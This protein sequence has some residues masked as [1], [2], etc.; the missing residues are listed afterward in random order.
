MAAISR[1]LCRRLGRTSHYADTNLPLLKRATLPLG[2]LPHSRGEA[3]KATFKAT[4]LDHSQAQH[5]GLIAQRFDVLQEAV[6]WTVSQLHLWWGNRPK[7]PSA[8]TRRT[9]SWSST[10][11]MRG[12]SRQSLCFPRG[13]WTFAFVQD[14]ESTIILLFQKQSGTN[15]V[16][17]QASKWSD[18]CLSEDRLFE[19]DRWLIAIVLEQSFD[20]W[21]ESWWPQG[22]FIIQFR[23]SHDCSFS[24]H[25]LFSLI[26]WL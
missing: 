6:H 14:R 24:P 17:W 19:M 13:L 2:P 23:Q 8:E 4:A 18:D 12:S 22:R 7:R 20:H 15:V 21:A 26:N 10:V 11:E 5:I 16:W 9:G 25:V 3:P 1:Q